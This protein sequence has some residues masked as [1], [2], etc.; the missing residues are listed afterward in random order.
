ML[1]EVLVRLE[2]QLV[3][4]T[5]VLR[6]LIDAIVRDCGPEKHTQAAPA[7]IYH[8]P[9]SA[10]PTKKKVSKKEAGITLVPTPAPAPSVAEQAAPAPVIQ[11]APVVAT[12][13]VSVAAEAETVESTEEEGQ[14]VEYMKHVVPA[15]RAILA[16]H[17]NTTGK[18]IL[19]DVLNVFDIKTIDNKVDVSQ[20]KPENYAEFLAYLS[21]LDTAA[22]I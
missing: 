6:A 16:K 14:K 8:E 13:A 21:D 17:G 4:N 20:L 11:A 9:V 19:A 18:K 22:T 5:N 7:P 2:I 1:E 15:C 10:A 12:P 3:E